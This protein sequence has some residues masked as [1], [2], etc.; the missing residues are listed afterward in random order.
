MNTGVAS[1]YPIASTYPAC[2]IGHYSSSDSWPNCY[3]NDGSHT[4]WNWVSAP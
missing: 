2:Y 4:R 3:V 1:N